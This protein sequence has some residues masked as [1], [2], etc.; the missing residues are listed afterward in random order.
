MCWRIKPPIEL[1][2]ENKKE[3]KV[4]HHKHNLSCFICS[5]EVQIY[6]QYLISFICA[7]S[8]VCLLVKLVN[9][10][11]I[12]RKPM[13]SVPNQIARRLLATSLSLWTDSNHFPNCTLFLLHLSHSFLTPPHHFATKWMHQPH[14][15][16]LPPTRPPCQLLTE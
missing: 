5:P 12:C 8:P 2:K 13:S 15:W 1:H 10:F 4:Y 7:S 14:Y 3:R 16:P 11:S 9:L 6:F